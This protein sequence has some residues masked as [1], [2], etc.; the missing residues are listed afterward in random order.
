LTHEISKTMSQ[1]RNGFSL[2]ELFAATV[3]TAALM[4]LTLECV[5]LAHAVRRSGE[6]RSVAVQE[7]NNLMEALFARPYDELNEADVSG[8]A[9][10]EPAAKRLPNGVLSVKVDEATDEL[11]AKRIAIEIAWTDRAGNRTA[12]V[13]LTAWRYQLAEAADE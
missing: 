13:R 3:L 1:Q 5:Q 9:L 6:Q 2:I 10:S 4:A 7:A 8:V 12:P 11:P